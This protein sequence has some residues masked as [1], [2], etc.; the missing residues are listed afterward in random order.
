MKILAGQSIIK[1]V[2]ALVLKEPL[3]PDKSRYC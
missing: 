3:I 2:T 1:V